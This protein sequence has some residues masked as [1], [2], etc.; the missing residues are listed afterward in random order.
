MPQFAHPRAAFG[1]ILE[2][3]VVDLGWLGVATLLAFAGAFVAFVRYD[4]R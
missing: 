3:A 1:D 4:V 2:T